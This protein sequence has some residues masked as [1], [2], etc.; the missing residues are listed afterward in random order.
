MRGRGG[1]RRVPGRR[2][3]ETHHHGS[4]PANKMYPVR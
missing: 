1:G 3:Y 4:D 2:A